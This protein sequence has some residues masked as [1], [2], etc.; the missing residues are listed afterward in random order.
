MANINGK[1]GA[2]AGEPSRN[3]NG[4]T[5]QDKSLTHLIRQGGSTRVVL[6]NGRKV[7]RS[8]ALSEMLWNAVLT[9]NLVMLDGKEI[10]LGAKDLIGLSHSLL[11]RIDGMPRQAMEVTQTTQET[12]VSVDEMA[13]AMRELG[14]WRDAQNGNE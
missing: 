6:P 9:G 8:K 7:N 12:I 13:T 1:G 5:P 3:P 4:R 2:K 14:E 10:R 11:N